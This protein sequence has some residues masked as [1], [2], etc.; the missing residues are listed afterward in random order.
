MREIKFRAWD[1]ETKLLL[2]GDEIEES[3]LSAH[4]SYGELCISNQDEHGNY[5]ELEIMQYTG[6]Q[7][8]KGKE[9]YVGDVLRL[10]SPTEYYGIQAY[11][12]P[13]KNGHG[14]LF[15]VVKLDCGYILRH[16]SFFGKRDD[17]IWEAPNWVHHGW[18]I[19]DNYKFWN[20]QRTFEIQG[21][22]YE[23]PHLLEV[24]SK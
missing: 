21:N 16:I 6:L 12:F 19:I 17:S 1:K 2:D 10:N 18:T 8:S 4:L 24:E 9:I 14:E 20:E 3:S 11:G 22:I 15:G 5:Y 13:T 23:H 7:D